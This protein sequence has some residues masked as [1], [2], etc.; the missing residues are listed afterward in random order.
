MMMMIN[1]HILLT[2][3][4]H[5]NFS[6]SFLT[7]EFCK[8]AA[9]VAGLFVVR[10]IYQLFQAPSIES[11]EATATAPL[12]HA[13]D[14]ATITIYGF[15]DGPNDD[16]DDDGN[17]NNNMESKKRGVLD[18]SPYVM[19]TEV[20]LKLIGVAYVKV[21][22]APQNNPRAKVPY[23]NVYGTM[24]DDSERIIHAI[25]KKTGK[26]PDKELTPEQADQGRLLQSMLHD[27]LYFI[28]VHSMF[29]TAKGRANFDALVGK[30]APP[31]IRQLVVAMVNRNMYSYMYGQG[32]GRYPR[33][34]VIQKGK[35]LVQ[36]LERILAPG[37]KKN[38]KGSRYILGTTFPTS[39][40]VDCFTYLSEAFYEQSYQADSIWTREEFPNA[41]SYVDHMRDILS[42]PELNKTQK[43]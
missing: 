18:T 8:G 2:M 25:K 16:D 10:R 20:F 12:T 1:D 29:G 40:D 23:A 6:S 5:L 39:C 13:G 21:K 28:F 33:A 34:E 42:L 9:A 27:N 22:G 37:N 43:K 19:R 41:A 3:N 14:D 31:V 24:V 17:N 26:D 11:M 32:I 38:N 35:E 36:L 4:E 30:E 7:R 15:D